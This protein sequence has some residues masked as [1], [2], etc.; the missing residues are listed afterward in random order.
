MST[1]HS[2]AS[3]PFR[4]VKHK[5]AQLFHSY[6][7]Q[8]E[9]LKSSPGYFITFPLLDKKAIKSGIFSRNRLLMII[10]KSL[11]YMDGAFTSYFGKHR[12]KMKQL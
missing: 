1:F 2:E 4:N 6:I 3:I 10:L 11:V 7:F 8:E 9:K 12:C 5:L